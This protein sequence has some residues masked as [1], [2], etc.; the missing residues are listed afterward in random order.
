MPETDAVQHDE[1]SFHSVDQSQQV[2]EVIHGRL[3]QNGTPIQ[4]WQLTDEQLKEYFPEKY[5]AKFG[6]QP[7]YC[8][9]GCGRELVLHHK[10]GFI[11]HMKS[12]HREFYD[13]HKELLAENDMRKLFELLRAVA[14]G[15]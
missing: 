6:A 2:Y 1:D 13:E 5:A 14:A 15:H 3:H 9:I 8:P 11:V 12:K 7:E 4:D 10:P